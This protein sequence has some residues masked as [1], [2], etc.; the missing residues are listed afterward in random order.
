[1]PKLNLAELRKMRESSKQERSLREG[2]F[3]G[4]VLVHLE[5][6][7]IA[8]GARDIMEALVEEF[9]DRQ[10]SD[11]MLTSSGCVGLCSEE[12][13]ITVELKGF[14][15]VK[16]G[17][18]TPE[19]VVRILEEHIIGGHIIEELALGMGSERVG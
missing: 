7:G 5:S 17:K 8:V 11:I 18:L 14:P 3:R 10:I 9:E 12:P 15:P 2:D 19:R 6:C 16:Y 1:M 13:M 4:K